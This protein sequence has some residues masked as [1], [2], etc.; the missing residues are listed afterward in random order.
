M[1]GK[2]WLVV[3]VKIGII[4]VGRMGFSLV[5]GLLASGTKQNDI[6]I[7]DKSSERLN[8]AKRELRVKE[9]SNNRELVARSDLV[10]LAVKPNDVERVLDEIR[11]AL[12]RRLFISFAAGVPIKSIEE[13][14]GK[15]A[16]VI[17]VMPNIACSVLEGVLTYSSGKR[18]TARD[19]KIVKGLLRKLGFVVKVGEGKLDAITGLS[20]S[21][22]AYLSLV[23]EA[24][25]QAG[26][27]ESLSR[28]LATKLAA[29]TAKGAGEL[30]LKSGKAPA[31][32]IE[33]VRSP[34]GTTAEGLKVLE[35]RRVAE[36][37]REAVKAAAK[38]SKELSR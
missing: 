9:T 18:V 22:P 10:F 31:E 28:E 25:A 24:L 1:A 17:R 8:V 5:K 32:L 4:G 11:D 35:E 38:R 29:Q 34:K 16:K 6:M 7:S 20:G 13:G 15:K 3:S 37:M 33:M 27:E 36:A 26:A 19:E 30:V 12:G 14:L 2:T 23:I 21:G